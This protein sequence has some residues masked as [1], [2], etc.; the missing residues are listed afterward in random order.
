LNEEEPDMR[1]SADE[2][3]R[4][5]HEAYE[6][7]RR[8]QIWREESARAS[9][10]PAASPTPASSRAPQETH[11]RRVAEHGG[12]TDEEDGEPGSATMYLSLGAFAM[13]L[14]SPRNDLVF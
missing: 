8:D 10:T 4:A 12:H 14:L 5:L 11:Q 1:L 6:K 9:S 13:D 2:K 7:T 3:V